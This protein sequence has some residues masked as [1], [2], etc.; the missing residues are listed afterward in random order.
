MKIKTLKNYGEKMSKLSPSKRACLYIEKDGR[1]HN[2]L[3]VVE[4]FATALEAVEMLRQAG[5]RV[6]G[7]KSGGTAYFFAI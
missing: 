4:S 2:G 3:G 1:A 7:S 6:N 5:W